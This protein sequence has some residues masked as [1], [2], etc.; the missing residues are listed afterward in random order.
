MLRHASKG[1]QVYLFRAKKGHSARH[2]GL[3]TTVRSRVKVNAERP[4]KAVE[5]KECQTCGR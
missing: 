4:Q 1:E 5:D 3:F 2:G